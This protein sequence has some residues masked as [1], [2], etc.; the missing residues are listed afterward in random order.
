MNENGRNPDTKGRDFALIKDHTSFDEPPS[1]KEEFVRKLFH[2][3]A[4]MIPAGYHVFQCSIEIII[5]AFLVILIL[6]IPI[7]F[8]RI[9]FPTFFLNRYV[10]RSE[11]NKIAVYVP[12]TLVWLGL[13]L[14]AFWDFYPF[15]YAEA[16]IVSTVVGDAAA[17]L[18]GKRFGTHQLLRTQHKTVEG[19]LAGFVVTWLISGGFL[20][21]TD[22]QYGPL[23]GFGIAIVFLLTDL[24]ENPPTDLLCDNILNPILGTVIAALIAAG[25]AKF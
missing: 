21:W 1:I 16:A 23:L 11:E 24:K 22:I 9:R 7:E 25:L 8:V 10:R 17:A 20:I 19:A 3:I 6:F 4:F 14:G 5:L 2:L 12:T 18:I 13:T 15:E